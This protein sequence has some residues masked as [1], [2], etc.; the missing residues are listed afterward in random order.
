MKKSVQIPI[1][2]G[3][4]V[5]A[6]ARKGITTESQKV[7]RVLYK[8]I[9]EHYKSIESTNN[10]NV[11]D[12]QCRYLIVDDI[13]IPL[14]ESVMINKYKP[15]WNIIVEGFGN[16]DP[17]SGRRNQKRSAWDELHPGRSWAEKLPPAQQTIED[18]KTEI[19]TYTETIIDHVQNFD[20]PIAD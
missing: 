16:H 6:G 19:A 20:M 12:F 7:T 13:W 15:L 1:Y 5:P 2:V 14:G 10:L 11:N 18:L 17:G 9:Q 3:K 8:R 4:A